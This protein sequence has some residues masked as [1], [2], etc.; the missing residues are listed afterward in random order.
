MMFTVF[1]ALYGV[2]KHAW[3]LS[4]LLVS[5]SS[6]PSVIYGLCRY[7]KPPNPSIAIPTNAPV[8]R[9]ELDGFEYSTMVVVDT[10]TYDVASVYMSTLWKFFVG[11]PLSS[12]AP[13]I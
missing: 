1:F 10:K 6:A 9:L 13:R 11:Q 2:I 5:V 8:D 3:E 4:W 12:V 7:Y